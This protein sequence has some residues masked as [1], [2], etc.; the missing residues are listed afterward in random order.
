MNDWATQLPLAGLIFARCG[1]LL[2]V[3]P[4]FNLR[5]LPLSLRLG[6]AGLLAIALVPAV[7]TTAGTVGPGVYAA[8][9]VREAAVGVVTGFAAA[10]VFH[11]FTIAGQLLDTYLGAGSAAA[12]SAGNGPLT[13]FTYTLA[14]AIFVAIDGHHWVLAALADGLRTLPPGGALALG[15]L[16]G[17]MAPAR[18]MLYAGVAIAA[19][20]LAAIYA[21]DIAVAAF[22]R[23]APGLG[24]AEAATPVRWSAALLGFVVALPLFGALV[25]EH[26]AGSAQ[27]LA[28]ALALLGGQ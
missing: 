19:P 15:G 27:A 23:L 3:A 18:S 12:R 25:S 8:L 5:Q 28:M 26:A 11:A 1:G 20:A 4:P 24:L 9:L 21:A 13:A 6:L 14:A 17:I 16:S 7:T 2:A 22:D 10:L